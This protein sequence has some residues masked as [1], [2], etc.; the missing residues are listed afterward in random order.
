[1]MAYSGTQPYLLLIDGSWAWAGEGAGL[2]WDV[3]GVVDDWS[4][5]TTLAT[6]ADLLNMTADLVNMAVEDCRFTKNFSR[7]S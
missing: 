7:F 4:E 1:M 3:L 5:D 2:G 6:A